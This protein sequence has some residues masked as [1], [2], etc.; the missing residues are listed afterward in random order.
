M[1]FMISD[2]VTGRNTDRLVVVRGWMTAEAAKRVE[3]RILLTLLLKCHS[4]QQYVS[5]QWILA[6]PGAD[7]LPSTITA[8]SCPGLHL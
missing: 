5:L 8:W 7:Y 2:V 6:L 4:R 3:S 1:I